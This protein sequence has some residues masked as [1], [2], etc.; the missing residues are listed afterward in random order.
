VVTHPASSLA[1]D[2]GSSPAETSVLTT[3]IY[4]FMF[5]CS[6]SLTIRVLFCSG[7]AEYRYFLK[8]RFVFGSSSVNVGI[9][10]G[11]VL[12]RTWILVRFV[13]AGFGFLPISN[14]INI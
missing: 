12:G 1:Q 5:D 2:R 9:G 7:S 8:T 3:M 6:D 14:N 10:F 13:L 4:G 11:L